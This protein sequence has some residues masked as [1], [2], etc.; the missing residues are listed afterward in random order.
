VPVTI[1][2]PDCVAKTFPTYLELFE[3]LRVPVSA[4]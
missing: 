4:A 2:D 1:E 3:S